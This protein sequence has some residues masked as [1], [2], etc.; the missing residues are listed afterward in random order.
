MSFG[1]VSTKSSAEDMAEGRAEVMKRPFNIMAKP[2]GPSCNLSCDYCFYLHKAELYGGTGSFRMDDAVLERF[3]KTYIMSQP[4]PEVP[5]VWQGGEPTLRGLEFFQT[6]VELQKRHI[7]AGR[8][9]TNA[10]QTNGT[11]LNRAWAE[12]FRQEQFLVG[13]SLDGPQNFH[14][15]YRKDSAGRGTWTRVLGAFS[16]LREYNVDVNILCVVSRVNAEYPKQMYRFFRELGAEYVQ[17]IPLVEKGEQGAVSARSVTGSLYGSFLVTVFNEWVQDGLGDVFVQDFE[18]ALRGVAGMGSGLCVLSEE[19]GNQLILE[20]NGDLYS[21]DHFVSRDY[22]LG[23]IM[24]SD[25]SSM[26]NSDVQQAFRRKKTELPAACLECSVRNLC[27][28]GCPKN[29][30]ETENGTGLN[31]LCEGRKQFFTYV[32]PFMEILAAALKQGQFAVHAQKQLGELLKATWDVS[33]NDP[34]PC[35]SGVKYKK[36]CYD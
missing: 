25:L 34:C 5:F 35:G 28:G 33:R 16:L 27:H 19:C 36:C 9:F 24:S 6:A 31:W 1:S 4:G 15:Q 13:L 11:L 2:V 23:N 3:I 17:F 7:P 8:R 22:F 30:L 12:F 26:L 14:D 21:C 20:H 29:R 32:R 18:E 10:I